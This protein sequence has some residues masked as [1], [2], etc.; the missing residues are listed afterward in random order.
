MSVPEGLIIPA[1]GSSS[2]SSRCEKPVVYSGAEA[3]WLPGLW[4]ERSLQKDGFSH[5]DALCLA[6]QQPCNGRQNMQCILFSPGAGTQEAPDKGCSLQTLAPNTD[7]LIGS[8]IVK[9]PCGLRTC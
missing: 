1:F 6:W 2:L 3:L 4:T 7:A 8:E 9:W 5:L